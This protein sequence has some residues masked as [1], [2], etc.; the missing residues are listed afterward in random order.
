[1]VNMVS[2]HFNCS[3]TPLGFENPPS[4]KQCGKASQSNEA[5][6]F[7]KVKQLSTFHSTYIIE[8]Q[9][10]NLVNII[11]PFTAEVNGIRNVACMPKLIVHVCTSTISKGCNHGKG[12][13]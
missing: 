11:E 1:M 9:C 8:G 2:T 6:V 7:S 3:L 4:H 12:L 5:L 10:A 13:L